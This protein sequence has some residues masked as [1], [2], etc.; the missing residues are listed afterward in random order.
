LP[1]LAAELVSRRVA[2]V[3]SVEGPP[4]VFA[5]KTATTTIPIVFTVSDDPVRLGLVAS[6]A[7]PGWQPDRYQF[8]VD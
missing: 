6:L 5:A 4:V 3:V 1:A 8:F 2:V 7:Q